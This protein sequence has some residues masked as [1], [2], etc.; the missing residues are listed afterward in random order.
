MSDAVSVLLGN[1]LTL[2][3][4]GVFYLVYQLVSSYLLVVLHAI[5]LSEALRRPK[6][7]LLRLSRRR[8]GHAAVSSILVI[9]ILLTGVSV[10]VTFSWLSLLDLL[11]AM[12]HCRDYLA[13]TVNSTTLEEWGVQSFITDRLTDV[14]QQ[15]ASLEEDYNETAWWPAASQVVDALV[16]YSD[17]AALDANPSWPLPT[18]PTSWNDLMNADIKEKAME[19]WTH[20]S[21]RQEYLDG[22][23]KA[24]G[25]AAT[26]ASF[27][28]GV[29]HSLTTSMLTLIF[30]ISLTIGLLSSE[31]SILHELVGGFFG[32]SVES[33]FRRVLEGVFFYPVVLSLGRFVFTLMAGF[34]LYLRYPY[35]LAFLTFAQTGIP[36]LSAYPIAS[37]LPW[38]AYLILEQ[39]LLA[40]TVLAVLQYLVLATVEDYAVGESLQGIPSWIT[41]LSIVL[42]FENFGLRAF[43]VGPLTV[44][45]LSVGHSLLLSAVVPDD[46]SKAKV[47]ETDGRPQMSDTKL[48]MHARRLSVAVRSGPVGRPLDKE[49]S[50]E[51]EGTM[52]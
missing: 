48:R 6:D 49:T 4:V 17:G 44:S 14:R 34:S 46:A 25:Y 50:S 2:A 31:N 51:G 22:A 16:A 33:T 40:A 8:V 3:L 9:A 24:A 28:V 1:V 20:L 45:I 36:V 19:L 18:Y 35:L 47:S 11:Q 21:N 27:S 10:L 29:V 52:S 5:L 37:A 12:Q 41:G 7:L 23:Q 42:G 39:R 32:D 13:V 43:I 38:M 30:F 15:V 26:A